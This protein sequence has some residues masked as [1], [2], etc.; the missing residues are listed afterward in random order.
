M[1]KKKVPAQGGAMSEEGSYQHLLIERQGAVTRVTLNRPEVRN[2][3]NA[4]L[5]AELYGCFTAL[6][7]DEQTRV[8]V[9]AGAGPVF[10]AGADLNWMRASLEFSREE[11]IADALRMSDMFTAIDT[12]S[13][14]VVGR[15]HSA[16]LGGGT[17][18]A[19]VCDV[20]IAAEGTRFGFTEV[21]LGIAPAVISPFV[22][23]RIGPGYARAL[24]LTGE[25]FNADRAREIGLVHRVVPAE[26]LDAAVQETVKAL[27]SSGPM[28]VKA[29]KQL[30]QT[31][32][33]LGYEAVRQLTA[34][35]IAGL[36]VSPEGQEGIRAFL[37]KRRAGW[38]EDL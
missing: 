16:A 12:C 5:I 17:G 9:L 28:G 35:T 3:F 13:K 11:N 18:L 21:R 1:H 34:E 24:G 7:A 30:F 2:A 8:I 26:Q 6:G 38:V 33:G 27:L 4:G 31:V 19:C 29:S 20:V 23:R 36:R 10:S 32:P 22:L 15:I 14:P 37:E 25:M